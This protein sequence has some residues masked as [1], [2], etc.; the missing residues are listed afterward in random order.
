M[1][2]SSAGIVIRTPLNT[3]KRLGRAAQGVTVM[4]L[5]TGDRVAA[6]ALLNGDDEGDFDGN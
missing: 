1:L 5:N 2:I 3:I 6:V 4:N